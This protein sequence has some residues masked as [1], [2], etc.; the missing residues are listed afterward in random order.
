LSF[1][2]ETRRGRGAGF[3][4]VEMLVAVSLIGITLGVAA[5][6]YGRMFRAAAVTSY[7]DSTRHLRDP[8][9]TEAARQIQALIGPSLA[10]GTPSCAVGDQLLDRLGNAADGSAQ[11]DQPNFTADTKWDYIPRLVPNSKHPFLTECK[12]ILPSKVVG[13]ELHSCTRVT[14]DDSKVA[15]EC[16][17]APAD[18]AAGTSCFTDRYPVVLV[19]TKTYFKDIKTNQLIEC[20]PQQAQAKPQGAISVTRYWVYYSTVVGG[21]LRDA[22]FEGETFGG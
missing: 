11:V 19:M 21:G 4:L 15:A 12:G 2:L 9:T 1:C 20:N 5:F 3:S 7:F 14:F 17:K 10:G 13:G 8:V 18:R 6:A 16:K 22:V